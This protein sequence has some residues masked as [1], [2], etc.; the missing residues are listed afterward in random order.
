MLV[1][2]PEVAYATIYEDELLEYDLQKNYFV[3]RGEIKKKISQAA[4]EATK[5]QIVHSHFQPIGTSSTY[6]SE[7]KPLPRGCT[8]N[9]PSQ[10]VL[11]LPPP[12]PD[13]FQDDEQYGKTARQTALETTHGLTRS[14][15]IDK[16]GNRIITYDTTKRQELLHRFNNNPGKN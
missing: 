7:H 16:N 15:R 14:V 10:T 11:A 5:S 4:V 1:F 12:N 8:S 2:T 13:D 6:K 3:R 9:P